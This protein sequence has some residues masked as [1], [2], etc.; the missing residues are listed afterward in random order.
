MDE[1]RN[2]TKEILGFSFIMLAGIA[3]TIWGARIVYQ[4]LASLSWPSCPGRV[5]SSQV[6][7]IS[8]E[9]RDGPSYWAEVVY[10]YTVDGK[11]YT[12]ENVFFGQY[13]SGSPGPARRLVDRYPAGKE[14]T[15]HYAPD[16]PAL[17]VLEIGF[18]WAAFA[19]LLIGIIFT[20][21]GAAGIWYT[22]AASKKGEDV[23][24][25]N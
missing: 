11:E 8:H 23:K 22:V 17:A 14:V 2:R 12:S 1:D 15:V 20:A 6:K 21:V 16:N 9:P 25:Y 18:S 24:S 10:R 13:S 5:V 19:V 3:V 7:D 4:A